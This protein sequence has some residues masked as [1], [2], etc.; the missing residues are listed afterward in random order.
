MVVCTHIE[1]LVV[2]V[3]EP[4][5]VFRVVAFL[6]TLSGFAIQHG[7]ELGNIMRGFTWKESGNT[8][9]SVKDLSHHPGPGYDGMGFQE[10]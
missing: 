8:F 3:V 6:F 5:D 1:N 10:L 4:F 2:V 7:H 9:L